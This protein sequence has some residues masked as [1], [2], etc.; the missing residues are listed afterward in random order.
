MLC[1]EQGLGLYLGGTDRCDADRA[2][3][4]FHSYT[5]AILAKIGSVVVKELAES[6]SETRRLFWSIC[7]I[8]SL[9]SHR[10]LFCNLKIFL[11]ALGALVVIVGRLSEAGSLGELYVTRNSCS[12]EL[13]LVVLFKLGDDLHGK[14]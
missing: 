2:A 8:D 7:H 12:E 10:E 13:V 1:F 14:Q 5:A 3:L 4:V 11:G 6:A 9:N